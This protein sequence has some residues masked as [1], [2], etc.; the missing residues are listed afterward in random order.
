MNPRG[1]SDAVLVEE[2]TALA[3]EY[4]ARV[5]RGE[6]AESWAIDVN[7]VETELKRRLR[8]LRARA[9]RAAEEEA[10]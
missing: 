1:M 2:L 7:R 3:A 4:A 5:A 10:A 6:D 9:C 8:S